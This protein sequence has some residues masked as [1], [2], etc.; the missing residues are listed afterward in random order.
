LVGVLALLRPVVQAAWIGRELPAK[1]TAAF[2]R[3]EMDHP[4]FLLSRLIA[5]RNPPVLVE[6]QTIAGG[7]EL[8]FYRAEGRV[9]PAPCVVMIHGGSWEAGDRHQLPDLNHHLSHCGYAVAAV[10]YR[11]APGTVWPGQAD[12]IAA[13][14][15]HLRAHASSLAIDP[16]RLVLMGRSAGG[17]LATAI[18]YG[19]SDLAVRG[20]VSFYGPNDQLFE[21][22]I[23]RED[24]WLNAIQILRQFLGGPPEK[25]PEAYRTSSAYLIV[26]RDNAVPTLL[27][28]GYQDS[29]VWYQLSERLHAKLDILGAPNALV[30]LP[31]ANHAC[32]FNPNGPSGQLSWYA[33]EW[34][35]AAVTK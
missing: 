18:A 33:L 27:V 12:D 26:N 29:L 22:G 19:R 20:A 10:S 31:W 30:T 14:I 23:S 24:D 6:T 1:L 11:L 17:Q 25:A 28:H 8:D 3:V 5:P 4:P 32:D 16:T 2:G 9:G 13:A 34:F 35:L 15:S 7:L 21:W